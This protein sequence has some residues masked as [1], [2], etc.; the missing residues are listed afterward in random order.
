MKSSIK[1]FILAISFIFF[2]GC[3]KENN[4]TTAKNFFEFKECFTEKPFNFFLKYDIY[5]QENFDAISFPVNIFIE[6]H[7][8]AYLKNKYSDEDFNIIQKE[9]ISKSIYHSKLKDTLKT[10]VP[11]IKIPNQKIGF[12][13]PKLNDPFVNFQ[14]KINE[15]K[16]FVL[17]FKNE[18]GFFFSDRGIKEIE[19]SFYFNPKSVY[20]K[21]Y[22]NGA[23]IDPTKNTIYY[24]VMVW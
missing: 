17:I 6:G 23:I 12:P 8:S 7:C 11:D 22:S 3:K 1:Y 24:W 19:E 9:L 14:N 20:G 16:S 10:T 2:I 18:K 5:N 15:E 21:G 4:K 13:I